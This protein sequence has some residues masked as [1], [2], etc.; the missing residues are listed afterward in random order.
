MTDIAQIAAGLSEGV[1]RALIA[2]HSDG[3]LGFYF[4]RWWNADAR[5]LRELIKA[6]MGV[7][8]WSGVCLYKKGLAVRNHLISQR[9]TTA[10][11]QQNGEE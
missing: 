6:D 2:A 5:I 8:V 3:S 7:R 9:D 11:N 10:D 4:V 1:K